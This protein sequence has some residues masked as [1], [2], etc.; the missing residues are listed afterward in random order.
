MMLCARDVSFTIDRRT[1]V[2]RV[3][4]EVAAGEFFG[5]VGPNGS[6]KTTLLRMLAGLRPPSSGVVLLGGVPMTALGRRDLAQRVA[7]VEQQAETSERLSAR[8]AVELGRT[9]HLSALT[10]WSRRDEA[11]VTAMIDLV[12]M[13]GFAARPW[14]KLSGGERQR[15]HIARALAQEPRLLLLDEPT[16]HLD[17]EHQIG[18]LALVR[19]LGITVVAVLHDLNHA[20]MFCD[21][22][23][24][25]QDGLVCAVGPPPE[26]LTRDRL[27]GVFNVDARVENDG[28]GGCFIRYTRPCPVHPRVAFGDFP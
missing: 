7:L 17:I 8:Q 21:R 27:A 19:A 22:I 14:H 13:A 20:A 11:V 12:G 28:E 24:V 6:G 2:D 10:P 23:A 26:I 1:I 25:M 3:H 15:L 5:I 9:P 16:N 4:L 18:L